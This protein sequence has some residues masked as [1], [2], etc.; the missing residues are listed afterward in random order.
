MGDWKPCNEPVNIHL[1]TPLARMATIEHI[2]ARGKR[3]IFEIPD[4]GAIG[5]ALGACCTRHAIGA[6][7]L[8]IQFGR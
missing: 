5:Q 4:T 2:E 7:L 3:G 1:W 8:C 6:I